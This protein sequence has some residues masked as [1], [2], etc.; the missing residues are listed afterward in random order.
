M[1]VPTPGAPPAPQPPISLKPRRLSPPSTSHRACSCPSL[2]PILSLPPTAP[3]PTIAPHTQSTSCLSCTAS[4]VPL[5]VPHPSA[6]SSLITFPAHQSHPQY[7]HKP[8]QLLPPRSFPVSSCA[9]NIPTIYRSAPPRPAHS[10]SSTL[11]APPPGSAIATHR[12]RYA[13]RPGRCTALRPFCRS[14]SFK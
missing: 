1:P 2:Y 14:M 7:T 12:P 10:L 8:P 6:T 13:K 11:K 5:S 4:V 3:Q 9:E